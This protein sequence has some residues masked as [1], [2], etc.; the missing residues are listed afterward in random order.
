MNKG[1]FKFMMGVCVGFLLTRYMSFPPTWTLIASLFGFSLFF[2]FDKLVHVVGFF[3]LCTLM[4]YLP[5][6]WID[7]F[8][9]YEPLMYLYL[10]LVLV[11]N[12]FPKEYKPLFVNEGDITRFPVITI[13]DPIL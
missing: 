13:T 3:F 12:Y 10:M 4:I 9:W 6:T 2:S 5:C 8:K 7:G 1:Y 11:Y